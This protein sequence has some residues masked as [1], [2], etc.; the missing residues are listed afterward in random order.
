M[1]KRTHADGHMQTD[2]CGLA[3]S[4]VRVESVAGLGLDHGEGEICVRR[5]EPE[6]GE[7]GDLDLG[8]GGWFRTGDL[9]RW[10][11]GGAEGGAE[12]RLS[13]LD[14]ASAAMV[15]RG[16]E[17][18]CPSRLESTIDAALSLL[19]I[20]HCAE[21]CC[22][23][24]QPRTPRKHAAKHAH[25]HTP[26]RIS[27]AR[28]RKHARPPHTTRALPSLPS[29]SMRPCAGALREVSVGDLSDMT[30]RSCRGR[31]CDT[32][33]LPCTRCSLPLCQVLAAA[34]DESIT[35]AISL[36]AP[37]AGGL[38]ASARGSRGG[39]ELDRLGGALSAALD[40]G[41]G[42]A[43]G[44][45]VASPLALRPPAGSAARPST[46]PAARPATRPGGA[47]SSSAPAPLPPSPLPSEAEGE[48]EGEAQFLLAALRAAGSA[49]GLRPFEL[50]GRVLCDE[51][52]WDASSG[53]RLPS[54]RIDRAAVARRVGVGASV[55][56]ASVGLIS[57][58]LASVGLASVGL[59][60]VGLASVG[61]AMDGDAPSLPP[62]RTDKNKTDPR[63]DPPRPSLLLGLPLELAAHSL[64]T[65]DTR[66]L[67]RLAC[68]GREVHL[69]VEAS[70][71]LRAAE[72]RRWVPPAPF[73]GFNAL[74]W[75]S[76][77]LWME[78]RTQAPHTRRR[79]LAAAHAPPPRRQAPGR[80]PTGTPPSL[81][82]PPLPPPP[83][84]R[85]AARRR[86]RCWLRDTSTRC[87]WARATRSSAA[88]RRGRQEIP[89][90][91]RSAQNP[92]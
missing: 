33:V 17:V 89:T 46:R 83:S 92:S 43:R 24:R 5:A 29:A 15:L 58:G 9:G 65:L 50:P 25:R 85:C 21:E 80:H 78:V 79:I 18:V 74:P 23:R 32:P 14:R 20:A 64:R 76:S 16:G 88:A 10:E 51:G 69:A 36:R 72:G 62:P 31:H 66:S 6:I 73:Q 82:T 53:C 84:G 70:L 45:A 90:H 38:R 19:A 40:G 30:S 54:G 27:H 48:A 22:V 91:T 41:F 67:F 55:G 1:T 13:V 61:G 52:P 77:L 11:E 7:K 56:L 12:R 42:G 37:A 4:Q 28:A 63:P 81:P 60:S 34:G 57:V 87:C 59:A 44:W 2:T 86:A 75:L 3:S 71:R 35:V 39:L 47:S 49:K 8:P 26:P 68:A